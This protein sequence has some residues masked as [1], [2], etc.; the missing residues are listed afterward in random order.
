MRARKKKNID[1]RLANCEHFIVDKIIQADKKLYLEIGC[2]KGKFITALATA[3]PSSN[4]YGLEKV[5]SIVVM[6]ME[7]AREAAVE[8]LHFLIDDAVSLPDKCPPGSVDVI[9]LNFSDPWPKKKQAK[10]RLT[11]HSFLNIYRGLLKPEGYV[12]FKTDN[13]KLFD[14]SV[15]EISSH[16]YEIFDLTRD[17]HNS[18]IYNPQTTEYEDK[19]SAL[20]QPIF[21]LKAR[22]IKG[23]VVNEE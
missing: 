2:G 10:R 18:D 3:D 6:A 13:E 4:Y 23:Y 1:T 20:G 12:F 16:G 11:Y 17:L 5:P 21:S 8:N 14:Y 19:F 9:F 7:K 15:E 22:P